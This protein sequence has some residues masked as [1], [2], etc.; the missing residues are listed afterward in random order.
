MEWRDTKTITGTVHHRFPWKITGGGCNDIKVN[1]KPPGP[2]KE[3]NH[4]TN[5]E[6]PNDINA[7]GLVLSMDEVPYTF[8]ELATGGCTVDW[9]LERA[10]MRSLPDSEE[11]RRQVGISSCWRMTFDWITHL[12]LYKPSTIA[13]SVIIFTSCPGSTKIVIKLEPS[14]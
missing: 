5:L 1:S 14:P 11:L 9:M 4:Q 13:G 3:F 7:T 8:V 6:T 2:P 10:H 12:T